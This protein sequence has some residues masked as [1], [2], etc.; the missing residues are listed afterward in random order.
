MA[1]CCP[2]KRILN[3]QVKAKGVMPDSP[4]KRGWKGIMEA[5]KRDGL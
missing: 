2:R 1:G 3:V 4:E 5:L